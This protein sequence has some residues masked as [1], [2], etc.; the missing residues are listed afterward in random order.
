MTA[1]SDQ[2]P[3][4]HNSPGRRNGLLT[5][6]LIL[7]G[8]ATLY[9]W[10][11]KLGTEPPP[12]VNAGGEFV[13]PPAKLSP[14][15]DRALDQRLKRGL[16]DREM[17]MLKTH[18]ENEKAPVRPLDRR[19]MEADQ[20]LPK[21]PHDLG[22]DTDQDDYAQRVHREL[23]EFQKQRALHVDTPEGKINSQMAHK[24]WMKDYRDNYER[25][26]AREFIRRAA[27]DG[28]HVELNKDLQVTALRPLN[29]RQP[30]RIPQNVPTAP[31]R[32]ETTH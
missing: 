1:K 15:A 10:G 25:E 24:R 3:S 27:E 23:A 26:F 32:P 21:A 17:E 19:Y 30:L 31:G 7:L 20:L 6:I 13:L 28:W 12:I 2:N 4:H 22:L 29:R 8:L 5:L 14:E 11:R 16:T 9:V 18:T